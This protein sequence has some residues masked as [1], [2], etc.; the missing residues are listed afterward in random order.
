[1]RSTSRLRVAACIAALCLAGQSCQRASPVS[2]QKAPE[3][4]VTPARSL[5][6][7]DMAP[8]FSLL[9]S[10]GKHYSLASYRGRQSVV[11]AWFSKAFSEG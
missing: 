2:E 11:L 8:D 7:G 3:P 1:M 4:I 9:G 5:A 10:D 6:V